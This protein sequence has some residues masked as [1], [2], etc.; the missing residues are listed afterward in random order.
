MCFELMIWGVPFQGG[1]F[2]PLCGPHRNPRKG[3]LSF[4][5]THGGQTHRAEGNGP[6][7]AQSESLTVIQAVR[8]QSLGLNREPR[9][10]LSRHFLDARQSDV[11]DSAL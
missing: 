9:R 1:A 7:P 6:T 11:A 10:T 4:L 5:P 3:F 8:P 2:S